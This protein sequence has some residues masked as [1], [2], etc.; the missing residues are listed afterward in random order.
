MN[1]DQPFAKPPKSKRIGGVL[2]SG[3]L[4]VPL[5]YSDDDARAAIVA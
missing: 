1:R 2:M 3:K 4:P 5:V